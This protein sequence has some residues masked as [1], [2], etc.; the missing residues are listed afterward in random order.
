MK[1]GAGYVIELAKL[2]T[3]E[4]QDMFRSV[5]WPS[6]TPLQIVEYEGYLAVRVKRNEFEMLP[7]NDRLEVVVKVEKLMN[8]ISQ[9]CPIYLEAV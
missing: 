8:E 3:P 6:G 1:H 9:H 7:K 4:I 5:K 2:Y